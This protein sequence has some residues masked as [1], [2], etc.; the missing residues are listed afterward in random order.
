ML[1]ILVHAERTGIDQKVDRQPRIHSQTAS[2]T[3]NKHPQESVGGSA[4]GPP[5]QSS[6]SALTAPPWQP[7]SLRIAGQL[8]CHPHPHAIV[9]DCQDEAQALVVDVP[10]HASTHK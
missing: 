3:T 9:V 6:A 4:I 7:S 5:R 10:A 8:I 1:I 2:Q